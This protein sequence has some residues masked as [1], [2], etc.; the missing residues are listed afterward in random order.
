MKIPDCEAVETS[1]G[2]RL[3]CNGAFGS[4]GIYN[5]VLYLQIHVVSHRWSP[6]RRLPLTRCLVWLLPAVAVAHLVRER[7]SVSA[8]RRRSLVTPSLLLLSP[9]LAGNRSATSSTLN[10][11]T[12]ATHPPPPETTPSPTVYFLALTQKLYILSLYSLQTQSLNLPRRAH[13]KSPPLPSS[14]CPGRRVPAHQHPP[15]TPSRPLSA[16]PRHRNPLPFSLSLLLSAP[17]TRTRFC[18]G[19]TH[20]CYPALLSTEACQLL[21]SSLVPFSTLS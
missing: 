4:L 5:F 3:V 19:Y 8:R 14:A 1:A 13:L 18:S 6:C 10:Q 16:L 9:T 15:P 17:T 20:Y 2:G 21:P 12:C 7:E 11:S